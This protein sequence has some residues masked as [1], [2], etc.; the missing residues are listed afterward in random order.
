MGGGGGRRL[1]TSPHTGC[2]KLACPGKNL[3]IEQLR[4]MHYKEMRPK[5]NLGVEG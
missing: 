3:G 5:K 1:P 4:S 2:I